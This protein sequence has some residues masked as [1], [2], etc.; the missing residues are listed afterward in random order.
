M[1][2][3]L[4]LVHRY[5]G[6]ALGVVVSLWCL[7]GFVM[8]YAQYPEL[9]ETEQLKGMEALNLDDCCHIPA[10]FSNIPIE[11]FRL[12][13]LDGRPALR[14]M[15]GPFQYVID[16]RNGA[17]LPGFSESDARSIANTAAGE[18]GLEGGIEFLGLLEQDQWT[19]HPAYGTHRPLFHFAANDSV[20][21]E[22][23]VS[24]TSGAVVQMTT[25]RE[26][27]WNWMG[28]VIHWLYPTILRQHPYVWIQTVIWLTIFSLFL[29]V[30]G[31]Y[32]GIRQYANRRNGLRSPYRGWALWHHYAGLVFGLF[33]L[34]WLFSGIFSVNP[35]GALEGRS[36]GPERTRLR[37]LQLDYNTSARFIGSL[38]KESLPDSVVRLDGSIIGDELQIIATHKEGQRI[39]LNPRTLEAEPLSATFFDRAGPA[40]RPGVTVS[41]AGWIHTGDAYYFSHHV[42]RGFPAFRIQYEDGER[43][44]LD[45]VSGELVYAA[46]RNRQWYRWVFNALHRGDFSSLVRSRPIWD[47]MMWPLMLGVTVGA[48]TGTWL[49]LRRL[50]RPEK[51][52]SYRGIRTMEPGPV[53]A[54]SKRPPI[55][56]R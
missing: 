7:S 20:G 8:M 53:A 47:L 55:T 15:E 42:P 56:A 19:V 1:F 33:T 24:S 11:R 39:R 12:E 3:L 52:R 51:R 36:F 25:S 43:L 6:I 22:F 5:L 49:G 46:D 17:Y 37:G 40:M 38:T 16:M 50:I 13:M 26:R 54:S 48:I 41:D 45:S 4:L 28:S 2:R 34:I 30:I 31:I 14:L 10:D 9:D 35:W 44:Y 29:T 32:I 18:F 21:T 23:Y 27:F